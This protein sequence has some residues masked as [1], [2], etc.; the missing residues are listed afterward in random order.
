MTRSF[1]PS[2]SRPADGVD[3]S[4]RPSTI[5]PLRTR[6][7]P[8]MAMSFSRPDPSSPVQVADAS[9]STGRR[10]FDQN[11]VRDFLRMVS[12]ELGRLH[13][14]E[15]FLEREL[16]TSSERIRTSIGAQFDDEALTRL[17][18]EETARVLNAARASRRTRSVRRPNSRQPGCCS[19]RA[20]KRPACARR[21]RS[22]RRAAGPT[23]QQ[24]PK[25]NCRW[26]SSRAA[27]WSTKPARTVNECSSELA[28]RRELAREQIEQ[29]VHGRDRLMQAFERARLVAVDVVVGDAAA[30]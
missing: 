4:V 11:E 18:G 1:R 20:T 15:R 6:S 10:G 17:L 5:S 16:S 26:P 9:F 14:R 7:V 23:Q 13:E 19:R 27:R 21:P 30:R 28:R 12:A 22:R 25:P 3:V 8:R 24:T 29:L 2:R